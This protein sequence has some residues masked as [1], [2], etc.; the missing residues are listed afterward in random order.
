[1]A[2]LFSGFP[3]KRPNVIPSNARMRAAAPRQTQQD[4]SS[5]TAVADQ[6]FTFPDPLPPSSSAPRISLAQS[7]SLSVSMG[8]VPPTL[9]VPRPLPL[10]LNSA[11]VRH[12]VKGNFMTLSARPKTVESGEWIAHQVVEHHRNL[13]NFVRVIHEKEDD[14]TTICNSSTCPKMS[15]GENRSYTWL[16]KD[17]EPVDLPAHEYLTLMQRWISGKVD[18]VA[19]FPSDPEGVSFFNH[20]DYSPPEGVYPF[21]QPVSDGWL[22][23]RSGFPKQFAGTAQLIFRQIFRVYAHL[24]WNH[25]ITPFYHLNLEKQLNSCFSHFILTATTLD[26]LKPGE[27]EPMQYLIDLWAADGTFPQ[28]SRPHSYADLDR[29]KYMIRLSSRA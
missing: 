21:P 4:A 8:I 28:G 27:L 17:H 24:Y 26:M 9:D 14:G 18:D 13:W 16:N 5:S 10:W 11:Y 29:G 23:S 7:P 1:M 3:A 2:N 19:M 25:F 15:A 6:Q 12:I 22:G 20:P